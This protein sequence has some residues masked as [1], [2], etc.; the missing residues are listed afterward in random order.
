MY[1]KCVLLKVLHKMNMHFKCSSHG[2]STT[3]RNEQDKS[4]TFHLAILETP[5]HVRNLIMY[6]NQLGVKFRELEPFFSIRLEG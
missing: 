5:Q 1:M 6:I 4:H 2:L 3:K